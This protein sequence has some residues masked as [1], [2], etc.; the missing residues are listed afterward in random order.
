[1]G[2]NP[3]FIQLLG[4]EIFMAVYAVKRRSCALSEIE[5]ELMGL[6]SKS[7]M[8]EILNFFREMEKRGYIEIGEVET[9]GK[10][11]FLLKPTDEFLKEFNISDLLLDRVATIK[12]LVDRVPPLSFETGIFEE[13]APGRIYNLMFSVVR[14][15]LLEGVEIGVISRLLEE[16]EDYATE[17]DSGFIICSLIVLLTVLL[18]VRDPRIRGSLNMLEKFEEQRMSA[19]NSLFWSKV[20]MHVAEAN[21][22]YRRSIRRAES[23]FRKLEKY[24]NF[25]MENMLLLRA[26]IASLKMLISV[27]SCME[28]FREIVQEIKEN[29]PSYGKGPYIKDRG[30]LLLTV[31]DRIGDCMKMEGGLRLKTLYFDLFNFLKSRLKGEDL[32]NLY[33]SLGSLL[34]ADRY[35]L[36]NQE[37]IETVLDFWEKEF[38]SAVKGKHLKLDKLKPMSEFMVHA[39]RLYSDKRP[40]IIESVLKI[41]V[42]DFGLDIDDP[43]NIFEEVIISL[44]SRNRKVNLD[45]LFML[46]D[47]AGSGPKR[48]RGKSKGWHPSEEIVSK[49]KDIIWVCSVTG[50]MDVLGEME[51]KIGSYPT[52]LEKLALLAEILYVHALQGGKY[53][54]GVLEVVEST[55]EIVR[56]LKV[57][58]FPDELNPE[59]LEKITKITVIV[60]TLGKTLAATMNPDIVEPI[61]ELCT[62]LP[63]YYDYFSIRKLLEA[64]IW[65]IKSIKHRI[66][67]SRCI[68]YN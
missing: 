7:S 6:V 33:Y 43:S 32:C 61:A 31:L 53:E 63:P 36:S 29:Y 28:M 58:Y 24:P 14:D 50:N 67:F 66:E 56:K 12:A 2:L 40:D 46:L 1:M 49:V 16:F 52:S 18:G 13:T 54:K 20:M 60:D 11:D 34:S 65:Q 39:M 57:P 38:D 47:L 8:R 42:T 26:K 21:I 30:K 9:A 48:S 10:K 44:W 25:P 64:M 5:N 37:L 62:E 4:L 22:L 3:T 68:E 41:D 19:D 15:H 59:Q 35:I 51:E 55:K 27:D 17:E 23:I 45:K